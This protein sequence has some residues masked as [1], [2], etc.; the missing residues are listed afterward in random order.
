MPN[1]KNTYRYQ[2]QQNRLPLEQLWFIDKSLARQ[3]AIERQGNLHNATTAAGDP[4]DP[5]IGNGNPAEPT[6]MTV[7]TGTEMVDQ[8]D[9]T[10]SAS[11]LQA[12]GTMTDSVNNP[13]N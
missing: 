4:R 7:S 1:T 3:I 11:G 9:P 6:R 8:P 5:N 2:E 10:T 13:I 12:T